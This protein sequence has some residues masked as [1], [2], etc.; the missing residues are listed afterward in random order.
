MVDVEAGIHARDQAVGL[1]GGKKRSTQ[2]GVLDM[3][4]R[5]PGHDGGRRS[6]SKSSGGHV[7]KRILVTSEVATTKPSSA[8]CLRVPWRQSRTW[9]GGAHDVENPIVVFAH[10][11]EEAGGEVAFSVLA[12]NDELGYPADLPSCQ[13]ERL[14]APEPVPAGRRPGLLRHRH[15][16]EYIRKLRLVLA[17]QSM[18]NSSVTDSHEYDDSFHIVH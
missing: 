3:V 9:P 17:S 4:D 12:M 6:R 16:A 18:N 1:I 7:E 11:R 14:S 10:L 2:L 5:R 8:T 13:D 15:G